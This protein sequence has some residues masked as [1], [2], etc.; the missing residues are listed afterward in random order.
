MSGYL[1]VFTGAMFSSKTSNLIKEVT[2]FADFH[3]ESNCL[4][5]N[6]SKDTRDSKNCISSHNSS[7]KG[8]SSKITV[9]STD[10]L[11]DVDINNYNVIGIDEASFFNDLKTAVELWLAFNK[12]IIV[13]GLDSDFMGQK[14]GQINE[15]LHLSDEFIKLRSFCAICLKENKDIITPNNLVFASFTSKISNSYDLID[16]GG[17]DKYFPTCRKHHRCFLQFK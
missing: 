2:Q 16:I 11:L 14:F 13:A 15:L 10:N 7:Y 6:S 3:Q 9:L 1:K 5:I 17:C 12:Y 4:I 8:L